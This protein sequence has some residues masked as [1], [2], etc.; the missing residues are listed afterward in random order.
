[1]D[2]VIKNNTDLLK[3]KD[4]FDTM[5]L[6]EHKK[7][8]IEDLDEEEISYSSNNSEIENEIIPESFLIEDLDI[9]IIPKKLLE[10]DYVK[11]FYKMKKK[12]NYYFIIITIKCF[13]LK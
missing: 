7:P 8:I 3:L 5:N 1:M 10:K 12:I 2:Y 4:M 13:L 11:N 9:N 6:D